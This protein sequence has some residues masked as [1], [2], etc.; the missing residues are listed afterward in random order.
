MKRQSFNTVSALRIEPHEASD[1]QIT[2]EETTGDTG[3][4]DIDAKH[5]NL[6]GDND[7]FEALI[8]R[9]QDALHRGE[10]RVRVVTRD[11]IRY[12]VE[13]FMRPGADGIHDRA[14]R[15]CQKLLES[16]SR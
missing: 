2:V 4:A 16:S 7:K 8:R 11:Q 10:D 9:L 14:K 12:Q 13:E 15:N 6:I 1:L 3:I 5:R